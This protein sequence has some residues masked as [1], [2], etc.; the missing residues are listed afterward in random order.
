MK[1]LKAIAAIAVAAS[2]LSA[3]ADVDSYLYWMVGDAD[4]GANVTY[5]TTYVSG[6]GS[7]DY[8]YAMIK[9]SGEDSYLTLYNTEGS[10]G[11]DILDKGVTAAAGFSSSP[12]FS[13]FL[14][15]L[16][17]ERPEGEDDVMVGWT[18][19]PY[20]TAMANYVYRDPTAAGST[21]VFTVSQVIPEPTS[22]LLLLLGLS[23]LALR[24][25]RA[26]AAA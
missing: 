19:L 20:S 7:V 12:A 24:R 1:A 25:R 5:D 9:I 22:G 13:S 18:T 6:G 23:G 8:D 4:T 16:Y 21:G 2:A 11:T 3:S 15:E 14:V 17:A 10:L 26:A